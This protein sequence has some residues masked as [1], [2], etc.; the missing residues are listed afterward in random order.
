M[1]DTLP[2]NNYTFQTVCTEKWLTFSRT[3]VF[4]GN[5]TV[6][7]AV[8]HPANFIMC[9]Q[10]KDAFTDLLQVGQWQ[11]GS[12]GW[13]SFAYCLCFTCRDP[14]GTKAEPNLCN[15]KNITGKVAITLWSAQYSWIFFKENKSIYCMC[16]QES[17]LQC[18]WEIHSQT[19]H[20]PEQRRPP[21]PK[22]TCT[23]WG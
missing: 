21:N 15:K 3:V 2:P 7:Q 18:V 5:T 17:L 20:S 10:G 19:Y 6:I 11:S 12:I 1:T 22:H 13:R 23:P 16:Q 8:I 9:H 4:L 14:Q